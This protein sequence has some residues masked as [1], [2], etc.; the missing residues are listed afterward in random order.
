MKLA[1]LTPILQELV[2]AFSPFFLETYKRQLQ[3]QEAPF[4]HHSLQ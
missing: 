4:W 3:I 1:V 2:R